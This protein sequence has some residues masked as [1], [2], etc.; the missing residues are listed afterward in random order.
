MTDSR[1][2]YPVRV[3]GASAPDAVSRGLWL[4]KWLLLFPHLVVLLFLWLAF[5]VVGIVAFFAILITGRYPRG[6]FDFAV[7]VLRWSWRGH[8][9]GYGA[10]GTHRDPPFTLADVA[11]Y[12]APLHVA[13]PRRLARGV[14]LGKGG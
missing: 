11:G 2:P 8:Y 7:G 6:L 3:D 9:Y 5:F 12:P 13:H 1:T 4:V 14:G 10:L